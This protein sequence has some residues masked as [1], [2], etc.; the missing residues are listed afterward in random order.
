MAQINFSFD[1]YPY[2]LEYT[3]RT[4]QALQEAG[5][6]DS[7]IETQ[8]LI[9]IPMLFKYSFMAHHRNMREEKIDEIYKKLGDKSGLI[10]QLG[11]MYY[12]AVSTLTDEPEDSGK[13]E[14]TVSG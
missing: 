12:E 8:P 10:K 6:D 13:V 4:A 11:T 1:G 5:F 3:R 7:K 14:W 2:T 9:M